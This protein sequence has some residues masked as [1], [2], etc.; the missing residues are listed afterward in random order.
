MKKEEKWKNAKW[1]FRSGILQESELFKSIEN[2]VDNLDID[3]FVHQQYFKYFPRFV[4][5]LSK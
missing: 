2:W 5:E 1:T 4:L 3:M